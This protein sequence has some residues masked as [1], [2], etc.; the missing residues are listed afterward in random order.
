[1]LSALRALSRFLIFPNSSI[2]F[3]RDATPRRVPAVSNKLTKRKEITVSRI[4]VNWKE[5][6]LPPGS[7]PFYSYDGE[8]TKEFIAAAEY[9]TDRGFDV[10]NNNFWYSPSPVPALMNKRFIIPFFYKGVPVGYAAR[11][12]GNPP[13]G[14]TKYARRNPPHNFV[15]GL[16]NQENKQI[17]IVTEGEIDAIITDG[18]AIGSNNCNAD[19]AH[20]INALHK[21][22]ILLP[23]ADKAGM[24]LVEQAI[25]YGWEVSFPDWT[26][27]KDAGDAQVKYGRMATVRS[28][29]DYAESNPVKIRILAKKY[30]R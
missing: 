1:V 7:Q 14:A 4:Q 15:Y 5:I 21:R 18:V 6:Q 12:I 19:Q 13:E 25:K 9:L 26:D 30:C 22:I 20:I 10:T 24:K 11:W 16:D 8:V 23:D 27:C 29:I 3:A 2:R 28:I 17:V